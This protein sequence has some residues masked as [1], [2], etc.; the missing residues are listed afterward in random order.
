MRRRVSIGRLAIFLVLLSAFA[1][2]NGGFSALALAWRH[3]LPYPNGILLNSY[4][5]FIAG[6]GVACFG[7]GGG[8]NEGPSGVGRDSFRW[9]FIGGGAFAMLLGAIWA[10]AALLAMR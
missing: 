5:I 9:L 3:P 2:L 10:S 4:A 8:G 1:V 7:D 6:A